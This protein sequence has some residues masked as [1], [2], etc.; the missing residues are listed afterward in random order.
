MNGATLV[1]DT[2]FSGFTPRCGVAPV[3]IAPNPLA[4]DA[5]HSVQLLRAIMDNTTVPLVFGNSYPMSPEALSSRGVNAT[6]AICPGGGCDADNHRLVND[7]DGGLFGT[8]GPISY[9]STPRNVSSITATSSLGKKLRSAFGL[10][11]WSSG[12]AR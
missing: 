6:L 3:A 9:F 7:M 10:T 12:I 4:L 5:S 8:T 2:V 11:T 1:F